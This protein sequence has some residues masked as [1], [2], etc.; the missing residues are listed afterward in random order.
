MTR[1]SK[2]DPVG[3]RLTV[4]G[5]PHSEAS[6]ERYFARLALSWA[7]GWPQTETVERARIAL[8]DHID[9]LD[10][11]IAAPTSGQEVSR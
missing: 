5:R 7:A 3:A 10:V 6:N 2:P 1:R 11:E 8:G 9:E 4:A